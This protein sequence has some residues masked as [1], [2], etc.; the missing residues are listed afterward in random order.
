MYAATPGRPPVHECTVYSLAT[1]LVLGNNKVEPA[2]I[3]C[4]NALGGLGA[5]NCALTP[6]HEWLLIGAVPGACICAL[7]HLPL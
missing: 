2:E 7:T 4:A 6:P 1:D 5:C 3:E